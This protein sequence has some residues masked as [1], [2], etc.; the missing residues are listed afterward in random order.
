MDFINLL[1]V[2]NRDELRQWFLEN[3][4]KEKAT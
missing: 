4:N 3:Y 1:S 2:K